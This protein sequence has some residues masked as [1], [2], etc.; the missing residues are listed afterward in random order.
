MTPPESEDVLR[1]LAGYDPETLAAWYVALNGFC[2]P[3]D[4]PIPPPAGWR[5][6]PRGRLRM[7]LSHPFFVAVCALTTPEARSKA[8][9]TLHLHR[10]VAEWEA[11]WDGH[12]EE[13]LC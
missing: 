7:P 9:W 4:F 10:S 8:W 6:T 3:L 11:W 1:Q 2:W 5:E 12:E 13:P